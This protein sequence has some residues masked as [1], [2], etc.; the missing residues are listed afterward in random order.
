MI[1]S[2][3]NNVYIEG[4]AIRIILPSESPASKQIEEEAK[5][6]NK[7]YNITGKRKRRSLVVM[8][9]GSTFYS[10]LKAETIYKRLNK[11]GETEE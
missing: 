2:L 3:G 5:K 9:D 10:L 1:I 8:S 4:N 11:E 7:L 6:R